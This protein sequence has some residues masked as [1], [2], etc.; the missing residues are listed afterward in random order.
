MKTE[1]LS[2]VKFSCFS[3]ENGFFSYIFW[4][5]AAADRS[6]WMA[7]G[8]NYSLNVVIKTLF[9]VLPLE[10]FGK[11]YQVSSKSHTHTQIIS[12]DCLCQVYLMIYFIEYCYLRCLQ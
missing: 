3:T 2:G 5:R 7:L 12:T 9:L 1:F 10:T 11:K 6:R 4:C 8:G